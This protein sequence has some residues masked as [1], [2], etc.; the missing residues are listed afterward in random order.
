MGTYQD[1]ARARRI[2]VIDDDPDIRSLLTLTLEQAGYEVDTAE[3]AKTALKRFAAGAY[4]LVTLDVYMPGCSGVELQR[5]L[6]EGF[7][8]G[9]RVS[10]NR[11]DRLPPILVLT[12]HAV[13]DE[14]RQLLSGERVVGVLSKP[15]DLERLVETVNDLLTYEDRK[16]SRRMMALTRLARVQR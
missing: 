12:G 1:S 7:G 8:Y 2:L 5:K 13:D 3:D 4:D 11:P 14:I 9:A 15:L 16:R 10:S 6:S